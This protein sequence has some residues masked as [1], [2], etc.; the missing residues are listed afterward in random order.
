YGG[1]A[2]FYNNAVSEGACGGYTSPS[3]K[4]VALNIAQYGNPGAVSKWCGQ[5]ILITYG[6]KS[7][8]ATVVDCCPS[9]AYG[10]LDMSKGLFG[11][12]ANF[13]AGVFQMSW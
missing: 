13:G 8:V 11:A 4:I 6:G 3:D 7:E 5:K 1:Q 10:S 12:F 2:T 9:C